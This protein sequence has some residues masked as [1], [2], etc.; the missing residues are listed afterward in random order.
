MAD[1]HIFQAAEDLFNDYVIKCL[2]YLIKYQARLN[3]S[4]INLDALIALGGKWGTNWTLYKDVTKQTMTVNQEKNRLRKL[5][6]AAF[7]TIY[8][9]IAASAFSPDDRIT[10]NLK[11]QATGKGSKIKVV[12]YAPVVSLETNAHLSHALRFQNPKTPEIGAIPEVHEIYLES[13]MGEANMADA[14]IPFANGMKVTHQLYQ[15][16]HTE[17]Y[18]GKTSYH[19]CYY[20]NTSGKRGPQSFI[21]SAVVG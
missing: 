1:R 4:D 2:A 19:R 11:G 9:D 17:G 16:I 18:V 3:F 13:Y 5:D 6:E 8:G 12:D 20:E 15:I 21:M 10:F 7:R 14:Y